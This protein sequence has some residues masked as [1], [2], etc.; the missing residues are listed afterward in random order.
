MLRQVHGSAGEAA[1]KEAGVMAGWRIGRLR[2]Q[3][4]LRFDKLACGVAYLP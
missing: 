4:F 2:R 3:K 1:E